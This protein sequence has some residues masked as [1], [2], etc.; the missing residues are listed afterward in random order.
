MTGCQS[1][2]KNASLKSQTNPHQQLQSQINSVMETAFSQVGR[3]YR[4]GGNTPE[5]GFDC[6]G[7][8]KWVYEQYDINL[9]R[10]SGH[11]LTVGQ[12]V[13]IEE[14]R[15]GDLVFFG[16]KRVSHV[17][18]YTGDNKYI[19]SPRRGKSIQE[20]KLTDRSRGERYMGGRR[21]IGPEMQQAKR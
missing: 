14:L 6:S 20:S 3:P 16:K 15:P 4:Y 8:V 11:M 13:G 17:G 9:P 1:T 12:P 21:L 5:T 2:G 7:F 10:H 19:H 18:I